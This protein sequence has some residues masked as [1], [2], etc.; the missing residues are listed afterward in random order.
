MSLTTVDRR[1]RSVH[2]EPPVDPGWVLAAPFRAHLRYLIDTTGLPWRALALAAG[3]EPSVVRGLL[4]GRAGRPLKRLD[5]DSAARLLRLS[6]ATVDQMSRRRVPCEGL[7][8]EV[9]ELYADGATVEDLSRWLRLPAP[10]V[11]ALLAGRATYCSALTALLGQ[12][13]SSARGRHALAA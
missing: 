5:P 1:T 4:H 9:A 2:P 7:L 12:A 8:R 6:P 3:V 11:R 13:L 10:Q